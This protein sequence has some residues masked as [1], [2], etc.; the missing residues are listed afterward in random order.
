MQKCGFNF[1]E[2]T[3]LHCYSS[4]NMTH[5]CS[6]TPFIENSSGGSASVYRSKYRGYKY[7]G[8]LQARKKLFEIH[9]NIVNTL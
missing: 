6:R 5:I 9:F 7:R 3:L 1:T 2:I 4:A 8:S